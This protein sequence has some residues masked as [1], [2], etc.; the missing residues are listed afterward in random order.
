MCNRKALKDEVEEASKELNNIEVNTYHKIENMKRNNEPLG[1]YDY[2]ICDECHYFFNDILF[3]YYTDLSYEWV[4]SQS[5][6]DTTVIFMS[7][8]AHSFFNMLRHNNI[9]K[10]E[11]TYVIPY[12]YDYVDNMF[13]YSDRNKVVDILN[14][15]LES[16]D[17]KAVFF[18]NSTDKAIEIYEL[19]KSVACFRCSESTRNKIAKKYNKKDAIRKYSDDL[20]T[21][22]ERILITTKVLDNGINLKDKKIKHIISEIFDMDSAIQCLGRKRK[23]GE[24]DT[25][26]FYIKKYNKAE[27]SVFEG[28]IN[29]KYKPLKLFIK[30]RATY[31]IMYGRDRSFNSEFIYRDEQTGEITYNNVAYLKFIIEKAEISFINNSSYVDRLFSKMDYSFMNKIDLDEEDKLIELEKL[32]NFLES[33][34]GKRMTGEDKNLIIE[35]I[36]YRQGGKLKKSCKKLNER[37]ETLNLPYK[38]LDK[39]SG[40]VRYWIVEKVG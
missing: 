6:K 23:L 3:N 21:F 37:L 40:S 11:N 33:F 28:Q 31:E 15:I 25:C 29:A 18:A 20:I 14:N 12:S 16:T 39:K 1:R 34:Q 7:G 10:E 27:I 2:I 36:N 9:V 26:N 30:D 5:N 19:F 35:T 22:D 13:L 32:N 8:T 17:D 24:E 38:I 4:I